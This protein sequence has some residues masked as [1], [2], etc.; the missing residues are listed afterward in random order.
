MNISNEARRVFSVLDFGAVG[1]G[2]TL[3]TH[4]IQT[5][6]DTCAKHAG[7]IV[8]FPSGRYL[9]GTIMLKDNVTLEL[10][11]EGCLLGSKD[12]ADYP[13]LE[14]AAYESRCLVYAAGAHTIALQGRG[15]IDGQGSAFPYGAEGFNFEDET[16]A[17][18]TQ[19]FIRPLLVRFL[20][21]QDVTIQDLTLQHSPAWCCHIEVC[22]GVRL[23]G[24][25]IFNRA[26]QNNDG[27]DLTDCEDVFA[28]NCKVDCGD[29]AFALK[30]GGRNIVITNCVISTR[31]AAFRVG[32]ESHGVYRDICVSNCVVYDTYGAAIKMQEV[33]GGI[34]EN[35]LFE[36]IVMENVTGP[37][38]IR[39]GGYLGWKNERKESL[40]IGVFRNVQFNN[41]RAKVADNAYPLP[42]EVPAFLGERKSCINI[43]GVPGYYVENVTLSN[44]HVTFPGGGTVEDAALDVPEL[45]DHYPEYH[46]FGTLPAYSLYVRHT[47]GL[48]LD[49]VKF[50]YM[51]SEKRPAVVCDDV[52]DLELAEF[53]AAADPDVAALVVLR[54]TRQAFI[55]GCRPLQPVRTFLRVEGVGSQEVILAGNDL[56]K[57]SQA[58]ELGRDASSMALVPAARG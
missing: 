14:Q 54:D 29:D 56:H 58:V 40:P 41:I 45:R 52:Q 17:H 1:D 37:I 7:G 20:K 21:C 49:N 53:R 11:P 57:A 42:H 2:V 6:I 32:P 3:N 4:A 25:H 24:V 34:M 35:I 27:F 22:K 9:S 15:T 5:A 16:A 8:F 26:N 47:R 23:D 33:E 48:V 10:S 44:L 46:M 55:H 28:S 19:T 31:W 13:A 51:G 43:T 30:E 50:D 38:S 36:N 18:S 12:L 39:L